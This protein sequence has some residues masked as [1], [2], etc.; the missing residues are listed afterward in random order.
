MRRRPPGPSCS[1]PVVSIEGIVAAAGGYGQ[2]SRLDLI[3]LRGRVHE[4]RIE[5]RSDRGEI[6]VEQV[7]VLPPDETVVAEG[8]RSGTRGAAFL[9]ASPSID[10]L[11][12]VPGFVPQRLTITGDRAIESRS[13]AT[14]V[15]DVELPTG[16]DHSDL[17]VRFDPR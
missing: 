12:I 2:D 9:V 13:H 11:V 1:R 15:I 10:V 17:V 16:V 5:V 4:V 7:F 8:K 3:D 14:R 6:R